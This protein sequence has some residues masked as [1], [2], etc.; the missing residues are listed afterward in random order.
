[1][2]RR[3]LL[4]AA[5]DLLFY[6]CVL[7]PV[8]II[9]SPAILLHWWRFRTHFIATGLFLPNVGRADGSKLPRRACM[10]LLKLAITL[11]LGLHLVL[12]CFVLEP[13][14][15]LVYEL[16]DAAADALAGRARAGAAAAPHAAP[17]P[18]VTHAASSECAAARAAASRYREFD[19]VWAALEGGGEGALGGGEKTV[20]HSW[21]AQGDVRL[22]RLSWLME[23]GTPGSAVHARHGGV[24]P[25]RQELP[26]E[27]FVGQL[28]ETFRPRCL[29]TPPHPP[30]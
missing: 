25:R 28:V 17:P 16:I 11:C 6:V 22:V 19:S 23:L 26:E 4:I 2:R 9:L 21:L 13:M 7:E 30:P 1:M 14:A 15:R 29:R 5:A 20:G 18:M 10:S 12:G 24:L 27:A 8:I 3:R